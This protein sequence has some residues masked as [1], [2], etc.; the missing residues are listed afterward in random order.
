MAFYHLALRLDTSFDDFF[1]FLDRRSEAGFVSREVAASGEHVHA[2]VYTRLKPNSY[3]VILK[4]EVAGLAGNGAYSVSECKDVEK[5]QR[6]IC[7]GE[8]AGS[9]VDCV[10]KC[11]LEYTDD[12]LWQLHQDYWALNRVV[13]L[14][15]ENSVLDYVIDRCK[16]EGVAWDDRRTISEMYIKE[17]VARSKPINLFSVKSNV[18]LIQVQLCP[19][20]SALKNLAAYVDL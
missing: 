20:D 3:R 8:F 12:K 19:D 11:G 7:K 15:R 5:Y 6:Y 14:R 10:W 17:L 2:Y 13:K 4:R 1:A 18:N 9:G 16:E